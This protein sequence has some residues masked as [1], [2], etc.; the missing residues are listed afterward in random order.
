MTVRISRTAI[1]LVAFA[2]VVVLIFTA[3]VSLSWRYVHDSPLMIYAGFLISHGT[4]P[5]RDLFDMNMPGTYFVMLLYLHQYADEMSTAPT[6][7]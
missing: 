3:V 4:V 1:A 2:G 5:Y 7:A 6:G